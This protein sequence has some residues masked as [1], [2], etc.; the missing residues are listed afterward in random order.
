MRTG[1]IAAAALVLVALA[2]T[3]GQAAEPG[4]TADPQ[5]G[6]RVWNA[7]PKGNETISW[8]G[9]CQSGV[10]QGPGVMQWFEDGKPSERDEGEWRDGKMIGR[11]VTA[12]ANG[13]RYEGE[14]RDGQRSGR[15]VYTW[16]NGNRYEGE[17]RDDKRN[18]HGVEIQADGSRYD[19]DYRDGHRDGH[20]IQTFANGDR[21][22]GQFRN[23]RPDGPGKYTSSGGV[24]EGVWN[25][26]C[27]KD[28]NRWAAVDI[29][30]AACS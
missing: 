25:H 12:W 20:G 19:G 6:C 24:F 14:F 1:M 21:Y 29:D 11:G 8:S 9:R 13:N 3:T 5:T 22:E 7:A 28:G 23:G 15:G 18:G 26:G 10:A 30:S 16:A 2:P 27:F 4:W 17:Y